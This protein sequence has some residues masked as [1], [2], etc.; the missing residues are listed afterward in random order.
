MYRF[1]GFTQ[2]ANNALNLAIESAG[3]LGHN[4]VGSEHILLGLLSEQEGQAY[5]ALSEAG[6]S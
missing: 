3:E 4:Y 5:K 1:N 6:I 2:D